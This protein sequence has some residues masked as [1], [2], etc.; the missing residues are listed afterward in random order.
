[1]KTV[2]ITMCLY[3]A[4]RKCQDIIVFTVP[5]GSSVTEIKAALSQAL[6]PQFC[7]LVLDSVV[8][9]DK[10]ILP[11]DFLIDADSRLSVLPPVCGG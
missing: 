9:N 5:A 7:D 6:G 8:A 4:F 1:M 11:R 3:G 10:T 2:T